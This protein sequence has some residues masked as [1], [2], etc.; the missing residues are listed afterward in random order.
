MFIPILYSNPNYR[1]DVASLHLYNFNN[2]NNFKL[3]VVGQDINYH[4]FDYRPDSGHGVT[5]LI[6]PSRVQTQ[7]VASLPIPKKD[8]S[9]IKIDF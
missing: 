4:Y 6:I 3:E 1:R 2:F 9:S 7:H 8:N 5:K